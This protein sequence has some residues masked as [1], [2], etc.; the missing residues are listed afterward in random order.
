MRK[1]RW[2]ERCKT[3]LILLL[4]LNAVFLGSQ[5]SVYQ[6]FFATA[7]QKTADT[8]K[9]KEASGVKEAA[10]PVCMA[11]TGTNGA[12]YGVKYD[13][14]ARD[15]AYERL[16][17]LMGEALGSACA[18]QKID[19]ARWEAL[20]QLPGVYFV[21]DAVFPLSVL[22]GW[23]QTEITSDFGG[24][25]FSELCIYVQDG[26]VRMAFLSEGMYYS[27]ETAVLPERVLLNLEQYKTNGAVFTFELESSPISETACFLLLTEEVE[28]R[29]LSWQD[30]VK[31]ERK[32]VDILQDLDVTIPTTAAYT[33]SDGTIVYVEGEIRVYISPDGTIT[34]RNLQEN[35]END[36]SISS[37]IRTAREFVEKTLLDYS[38][39]VAVWMTGTEEQQG[40]YTVFFS[41]YLA[42]GRIYLGENGY[43]AR[44]T[45]KDGMVREA[46]LLYRECRVSTEKSL[47]LP[48][49]Q[50][51]AAAGCRVQLYYL[52]G[53]GTALVP[54]WIEYQSE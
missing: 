38:G 15:A 35:P 24:N 44:I 7:L 26:S 25:V 21:Y 50:A 31:E 6:D 3:V 23:L 1:R 42:G 10:R 32:V 30:P 16:T 54:E 45:V 48:E 41:Y 11:I 13:D 52:A 12:H 19:Q 40:T 37:A 49:L 17:G 53:E 33:E 8:A 2:I 29:N 46:E 5:T 39:D 47:L 22:A 34:Y 28:Y 51:A 36:L 18:V 43:C 9:E 27:A 14:E 20:L 4:V